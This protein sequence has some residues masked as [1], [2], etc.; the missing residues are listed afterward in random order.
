[1]ANLWAET[2]PNNELPEDDLNDPHTCSKK[3]TEEMC[4][5]AHQ[6][7]AVRHPVVDVLGNIKKSGISSSVSNESVDSMLSSMGYTILT[8]ML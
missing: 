3:F 6:P 4:L 1:M 5:H 7:N 2:A 8:L